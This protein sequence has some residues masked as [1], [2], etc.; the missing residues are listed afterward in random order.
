MDNM[1]NKKQIFQYLHKIIGFAPKVCSFYDDN[2][3]SEIDIYIGIDRPDFGITTYSTIGLSDYPIGMVTQAGKQIRVE[4]IAICN[5]KDV[6]FPS[7]IANC[8]FNI[9]NDKYSCSPGTVYSDIL[10]A[11]F[12]NIDMKH[13]LFTTP[14]PWENLHG[15][16][17]DDKE[18]MWLLA[19]PISDNEFLYL[20]ENGSDALE[21]LLEKN[22]ID[23]FDINRKSVL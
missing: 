10:S 6:G 14:Y 23:I 16:E 21:E 7:A 5:S 12:D 17:N 2:E 1:Q 20:K 11:Y 18:I 15:I 19:V 8:A 3:T 13:I 9:M 4:F 22:N